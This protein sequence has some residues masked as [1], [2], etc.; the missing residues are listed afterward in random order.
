[1]NPSS[2][3]RRV[4]VVDDDPIVCAVVHELLTDRGFEVSQA[5]TA[6]EALD[7]T[8]GG[9]QGV[10][11]LD[12][13]LPDASG[14]EVFRRMR[15]IAP[16]NPVIFLTGFG[17]TDLA[18][19]SIRDGA[20]E[21]LEKA[22]LTERLVA[23]VESA[24]ASLTLAPPGQDSADDDAGWCPAGIVTSSPEMRSVLRALRNAV[25]SKVTVLIRGE[26]GTGKELIAKA[27]HEEGPRR[28]GPF[29]S[30]NC[31]SIPESLLEAEMFGYER[32]AF[33]GAAARKLG[34]F[35]LADRGTLFLDE[36]GEMHPAL[37]AKLLRVIQE[38]QFQR[39]GGVTTQHVDVRILSATHRNLEEEVASG[40]F[41][42]DLYYRLAVYSIHLPPLRERTGDVELLTQ[43]F[44]RKIARREGRPARALD[45]RVLEL[46]R[47]YSWPGNVRQLDN[48]VAYALVTAKGPV[49]TVADLPRHFLD[50]V[51]LDR[52]SDD[53][54]VGVAPPPLAP[55]ARA[56]GTAT[57]APPA[58]PSLDTFPTLAQA[59]SQH[60]R[61]ALLL[62]EGNKSRAA[63]LL[64]ISRTTLYRK[65][66]ELDLG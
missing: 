47:D 51:A 27:I 5:G 35:E 45:E 43:H 9:F 17:S 62:C 52:R 3:P 14:S 56:A 41:R 49:V 8:R 18:L 15:E 26:S 59:E 1:M 32:G 33:T 37:Q 4:M 31:A 10:V 19:E 23:T 54:S 64:D 38:R 7:P 11:V 20:F 58:A 39:L 42:E 65:A 36:I 12:M 53:G 34:R 24:F 48:I 60:I 66:E 44:A 61:A 25:D 29:V 50:A 57:P 40:R 55:A 21:F 16:D 46:F 28:T 22:N 13:W 2:S 30:I 6:A 63:R